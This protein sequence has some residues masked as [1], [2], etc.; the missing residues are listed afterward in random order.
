MRPQRLSDRLK[1]RQQPSLGGIAGNAYNGTKT[2][3]EQCFFDPLT[4]PKWCHWLAE[5]HPAL[6]RLPKQRLQCSSRRRGSGS[7]V[8][9]VTGSGAKRR[10]NASLSAILC[11]P[12]TRITTLPNGLRIA[13]ESSLPSC[14]AVVG[15]WIY[16]GSRFES[17]ATNGV[18]HFLKRMVFRGTEKRPVEGFGEGN[19]EHG[20]HLMI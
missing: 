5:W 15:V 3:L 2:T 20:D 10:H 12:E 8:T 14:V 1:R 13:T 11:S 16:F 4:T 9:T 17:N 6:L 18:A 19:W 7:S